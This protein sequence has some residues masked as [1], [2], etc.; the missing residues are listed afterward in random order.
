M[1]CS[2]NDCASKLQCAFPSVTLGELCS[3]KTSGLSSVGSNLFHHHRNNILAPPALR[4]LSSIRKMRIAQGSKE[5]CE[6][7]VTFWEAIVLRRH[8]FKGSNISSLHSTKFSFTLQYPVLHSQIESDNHPS[9]VIS[10]FMPHQ[11][12]KWGQM[13]IWKCLSRLCSCSE[14][15]SSGWERENP[16]PRLL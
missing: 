11:G 8:F 16:S 6:Y 3:Y 5:E 10:M 13:V 2:W 12:G 4:Q 14:I 7:L 15:C 9:S 1:L